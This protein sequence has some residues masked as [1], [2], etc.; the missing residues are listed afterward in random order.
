MRFMKYLLFLISSLLCGIISFAAL[1]FSIA[2]Y[3]NTLLPDIGGSNQYISYPHNTAFFLVI[4]SLISTAIPVFIVSFIPSQTNNKSG[5]GCSEKLFIRGLKFLFLFIVACTATFLLGVNGFLLFLSGFAQLY[6]FQAPS[7]PFIGMDM[8]AY[9]INESSI[10]TI[11][12]VGA[13]WMIVPT[14]IIFGILVIL[15]IVTKIAE[16]LIAFVSTPAG[17]MPSPVLESYTLSEYERYNLPET[18][19]EYDLRLK[20]EA[21]ERERIYQENMEEIDRRR[22]ERIQEA[23]EEEARR[24]RLKEE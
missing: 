10:I 1:A 13:L 7:L 3:Q 4:V 9:D 18:E 23:E 14:A 21:E 16:S 15:K 8:P 2:I 24:N 5:L 22:A 6:G 12:L 19:R 17:R 11:M 20:A